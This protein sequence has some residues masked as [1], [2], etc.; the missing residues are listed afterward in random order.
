MALPALNTTFKVSLGYH[1]N[2]FASRDSLV[3]QVKEIP[4]NG[5]SGIFAIFGADF[6]E[7]SER[8]EIIT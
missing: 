2:L 5:T 6:V 3:E 7:N 1:A 8:I 4:T